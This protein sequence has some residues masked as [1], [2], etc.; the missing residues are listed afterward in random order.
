MMSV[1]LQLCIDRVFR[2]SINFSIWPRDFDF[3]VFGLVW[4]LFR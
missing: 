3:D 1:A 4:F 2:L